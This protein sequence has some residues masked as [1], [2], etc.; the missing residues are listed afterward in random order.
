MFSWHIIHAKV[1]SR[2]GAK[3]KYVF[4]LHANRP[5]IFLASRLCAF[6]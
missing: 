5:L 6:A 1:Q 2:Q 3:E 4:G